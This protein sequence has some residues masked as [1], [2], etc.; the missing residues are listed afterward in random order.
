MDN[1][2]ICSSCGEDLREVG[3]YIKIYENYAFCTKSNRFVASSEDADVECTMCG[4]CDAYVDV[5]I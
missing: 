3:V 4:S 1:K 2:Y 5:E